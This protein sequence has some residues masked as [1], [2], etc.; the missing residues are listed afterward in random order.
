MDTRIA[1]SKASL[2]FLCFRAS[3]DSWTV[4]AL[5]ISCV[6]NAALPSISVASL[7]LEHYPGMTERS[8]EAIVAECRNRWPVQDVVIVHR[9]G[10]LGPEAQIVLVMVAGG[11]RP[12]V[13]AACEFLMDYLKTD[14]VFW[15]REAKSGG[16]RWVAST[17]GDRQRRTGWEQGR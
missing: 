11:H 17:D 9:V 8:I 3:G 1:N 16:D 2:L 13:F 12:E 7:E 6:D 5:C 14:A 4:L 10:E 15:K